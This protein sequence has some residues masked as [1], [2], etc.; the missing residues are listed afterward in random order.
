[1]IAVEKIK[2]T[3]PIN[4]Q[5]YFYLLCFIVYFVSVR[6]Y[7]P[8]SFARSNTGMGVVA[9][10]IFSG[11]YLLPIINIIYIL[12]RR[13]IASTVLFLLLSFTL[14]F[15]NFMKEKF[16][17]MPL[18]PGDLLLIKEAV[19]ATP[20]V[21]KY[22]VIA[23]ILLIPALSFFIIRKEKK[24]KPSLLIPSVVTLILLSVFIYLKKNNSFFHQCINNKYPVTCK[25]I[26]ALPNTKLNWLGDNESFKIYGFTTFFLSKSLDS[27]FYDKKQVNIQR[28]D[29]EKFINKDNTTIEE[30]EDKPDVV[31][32]MS[33]AHWN[34]SWM[35]GHIPDV[36]PNIDKLQISKM[37]SP[38]FGG[39]TA[40]VEF[41]VLTGLSTLMSDGELMY[42]SKIKRPIYSLARYFNNNGYESIAMHNNGKNFYNR[43]FVYPQLGFHQFISI[44]DMTK[45]NPAGGLTNSAGWAHDKILYDSLFKELNS[46]AKPKFIYAITVE[47]HGLY[48][49]NRYP[50]DSSIVLPSNLTGSSRNRLQTYITGVKRADEHL[51]KFIDK[52]KQSKRKTIVIFFGDHLPNLQDTYSDLGFIKNNKMQDE[53]YYETPLAVWSNFP[54]NKSV[55]QKPRIQSIFMA[56]SILKAIHMP[57]S[58]YFNFMSK[59]NSC[60]SYIHKIG[61]KKD[62]TCSAKSDELLTE[63]KN[64]N[65]DVIEGKNYTFDI[66][67]K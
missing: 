27:I 35:G 1:M 14:C 34:P 29:I 30:A 47:N 65:T 17:S 12:S 15:I 49:D 20:A 63:Y 50:A 41:E 16:L 56:P 24:E 11:L 58:P 59:L 2:E 44:S 43:S 9:R 7:G 66:M 23:L 40:N 25:F 67:T 60:Y 28:S 33:E 3:G 37:L 10:S 51:I 18:I 19:D 64:L 32:I 4:K 54:I 6:I 45:D 5:I 46:D 52:L 8:I 13:T 38:S 53:K 62:D 48:N 61:M 21:L 42:V 57:L 22:L 26:G 36:T 55:L 31:I 39:Q